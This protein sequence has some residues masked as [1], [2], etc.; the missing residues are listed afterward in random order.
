MA[1][2]GASLILL[3]AGYPR[4]A[5]PQDDPAKPA[6]LLIRASPGCSLVTQAGSGR[7]FDAWDD[8]LNASNNV[9]T[10]STAP[11]PMALSWE[12]PI[13]KLQKKVLPVADQVWDYH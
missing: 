7:C 5:C 13:Y 12:Y 1:K 10:K 6:E 8:K 4:L 9:H 3:S 2:P 11:S